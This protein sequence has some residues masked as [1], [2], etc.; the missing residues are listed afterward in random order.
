MWQLET[1]LGAYATRFDFG[2]KM[3]VAPLMEITGVGQARARDLFKAGFTTVEKI[4]SALP[5]KLLVS[6]PS[7]SRI[8]LTGV[9]KIVENAKR[10]LK[11]EALEAVSTADMLL[12]KSGGP[13]IQISSA[14]QSK[15]TKRRYI[16]SKDSGTNTVDY[17]QRKESVFKK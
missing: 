8:G 5:Q 13:G 1:L 3:D 7:F 4:A 2:V 15:S 11:R 6:V 9:Q 10:V 16:K 17:K 12:R 14:S